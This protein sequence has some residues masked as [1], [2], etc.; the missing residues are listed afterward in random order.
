MGNL[1]HFGSPTG[2]AYETAPPPKPQPLGLF[3]TL[4]VPNPK[5]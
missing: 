1:V 2:T 4:I 3:P 5:G